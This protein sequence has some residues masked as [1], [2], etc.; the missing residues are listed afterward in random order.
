M[1]I[2]SSD[3]VKRRTTTWPGMAAEI[4]QATRRDRI[5]PRAPVHLPAV[6]ERG[7]RREGGRAMHDKTHA[8]GP[9]RALS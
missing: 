1:G 9:R 5:K 2:S 6:Y 7:A 8:D 4:V 3:V